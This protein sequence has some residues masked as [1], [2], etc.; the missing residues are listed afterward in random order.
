MDGPSL[1]ESLDGVK[2][3][4]IPDPDPVYCTCGHVLER[5]GVCYGEAYCE[6][7]EDEGKEC[8]YFEEDA[9]HE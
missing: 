6:Q 7:C 2:P 5:H 1:H 3:D 9:K 8:P 4:D